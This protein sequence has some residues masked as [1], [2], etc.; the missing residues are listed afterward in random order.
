MEQITATARVVHH[1]THTI[2]QLLLAIIVVG[3]LTVVILRY[4]FGMGFIELQ[5]AVLYSFAALV[6]LSLPVAQADDTHVRVD[7]FRARQSAF[8][9]GRFD[10]VAMLALLL[11]FFGL[12]IWWVWPDVAYSWSIFEGSVETGGLPGLFLVKSCLP[13]ACV[14][15]I[16]Q[17]I[18]GMVARHG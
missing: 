15:M 2:C 5:D 6:V 12:T 3:Q 11:P 13:L 9:Q 17:G 18:A 16:L 8:W 4:V 14:L 10:D 1:T 7:V